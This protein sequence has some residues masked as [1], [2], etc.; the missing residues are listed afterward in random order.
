M[1]SLPLVDRIRRLFSHPAV[2]LA[3]A[4]GAGILLFGPG[5]HT[6]ERGTKV[7]S[8]ELATSRGA[9]PLFGPGVTIL[10]FWGEHCPP[11]RSEAPELTEVHAAL[12][13][14]GRVI[15]ISVDSADLP[16]ADRVGRAIGIG[17]PVAVLDR[18]LQDVFGVT[19]IP[20]TYVLD[21]QGVVRR[22]FV[23]AVSRRTLENAIAALE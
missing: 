23:G 19:V 14:R 7:R 20:T 10:N 5:G 6:V 22:S 13:G 8:R 17:F 2:F 21:D 12:H 1:E 15:G 18:D 11:C 4:L 9:V 3:L 16:S